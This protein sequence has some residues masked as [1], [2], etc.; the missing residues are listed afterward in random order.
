[1]AG[2]LTAFQ[3]G[4]FQCAFQVRLKACGVLGWPECDE[5]CRIVGDG[6]VCLDVKV[7]FESIVEE[8]NFVGV[9]GDL[10][11]INDTGVRSHSLE[12]GHAFIDQICV[13]M[14]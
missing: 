4:V 5:W 13:F 14:R 7:V 3:F 9:S 8:G 10:C 6:C 2:E 12:T 11:A 1:M